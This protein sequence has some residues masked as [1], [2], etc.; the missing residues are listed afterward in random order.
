MLEV[1][2]QSTV[3]DGGP[4]SASIH[5]TTRLWVY[6]SGQSTVTRE[7]RIIWHRPGCLLDWGEDT[8]GPSQER[9][10]WSSLNSIILPPRTFLFSSHDAA[11]NL[12]WW[13][14]M[15]GCREKLHPRLQNKWV[16]DS[17]LQPTSCLLFVTFTFLGLKSNALGR[18][19]TCVSSWF[20][21]DI[22][23]DTIDPL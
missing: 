13:T 18:V 10:V 6:I 11:S 8:R 7:G 2:L 1:P 23:L 19:L 3:W 16:I 21:L 22:V 5:S 15:Q 14:E 17:G 9:G 20:I 4:W 12:G